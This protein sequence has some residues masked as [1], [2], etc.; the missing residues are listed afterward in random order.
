MKENLQTLV[1]IAFT[2]KSLKKPSIMLHL[3]RYGYDAKWVCGYRKSC[4]S[5]TWTHRDT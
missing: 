4:E 2:D 5:R 3:Y 1:L